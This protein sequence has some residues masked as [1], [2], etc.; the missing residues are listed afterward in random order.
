M[1]AVALPVIAT[2]PIITQA[3]TCDQVAPEGRRLNAEDEER[4]A[5]TWWVW[6]AQAGADPYKFPQAESLR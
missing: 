6:Q 4:I 3:S 5:C 2:W 1:A